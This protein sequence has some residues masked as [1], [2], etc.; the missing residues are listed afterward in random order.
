MCRVVKK[1]SMCTSKEAD[2]HLSQKGEM[3]LKPQQSPSVPGKSNLCCCI[4]ANMTKKAW[5]KQH[6]VESFVSLAGNK[7][8]N[9]A[10]NNIFCIFFN[11]I[12]QRTN[13]ELMGTSSSLKPLLCFFP[14]P[15]FTSWF[16]ASY[17]VLW[18]AWLTLLLIGW[19]TWRRACASA[20]CGSTTSSAAGHPTRPLLPS[21]TSVRSGRAGRS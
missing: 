19:M 4:L 11:L 13:K 6:T 12:L 20:P 2:I 17:Q 8:K 5:K 9:S 16:P 14:P 3:N 21:E 18:L 1:N 7:T 15:P 10:N